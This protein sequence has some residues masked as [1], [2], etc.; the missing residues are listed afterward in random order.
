[1][2]CFMIHIYDNSIDMS[3]LDA[4]SSVMLF[5]FKTLICINKRNT[6]KTT[7]ILQNVTV[8]YTITRYICKFGRGTI[9][10][11]SA[12]TYEG[13]SSAKQTALCI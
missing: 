10:F 4:V 9:N 7:T 12:V 2:S 13:R 3:F 8:L 6:T 11:S 1:M 5:I